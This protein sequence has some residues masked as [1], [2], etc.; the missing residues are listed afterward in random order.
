M[1]SRTAFKLY[2]EIST[3]VDHVWAYTL[4]RYNARLYRL[5]SQRLPPRVGLS[6]QGA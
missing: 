1:Y 3:S 2:P 4:P 6:V 5:H